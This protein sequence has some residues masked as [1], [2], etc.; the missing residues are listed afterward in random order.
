MVCPGWEIRFP[1]F[2]RLLFGRGTDTDIKYLGYFDEAYIGHVKNKELRLRGSSGGIITGLLIFLLEN[3]IIDGAIVTSMDRNNPWRPLP[4]LGKTK[5]QILEGAGSKYTVSPTNSVLK[6]LVNL[7][8]RFALV[9]LPCHVHGVRKIAK[10]YEQIRGKI[11]YVMGLFCSTTLEM[12]ATL[13]ILKLTGIPL[14]E[15]DELKYRFGQWPGAIVASKKDG[16]IKKLHYSNYKDGAY[17][18]LSEL[19]SPERC[20]YCID[21]C[22]EFAD[23]SVADAWTKDKNGNYLYQEGDS[24]ILVRT[25]AGKELVDF[26]IND[27]S[28]Y[29]ERVSAEMV[30]RTHL[31]ADEKKKKNAF[32][33]L[34]RLKRNK[35]HLP[36]YFLQ[37]PQISTKDRVREYFF[38]MIHVL[39]QFQKFRYIL[40]S[41]LLSRPGII[42]IKIRQNLKKER[43]SKKMFP[44]IVTS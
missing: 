10:I 34:Q 39:S 18:Y 4:I 42:F 12:Q 6:E 8:G 43:K 20:R 21:T 1:E 31:K 26:M 38:H 16:S 25:D 44:K 17:N 24:M 33:N 29:L 9:G 11:I 41:I 22:N 5:G 19:Y 30:Y 32:I 2:N 27:Q 13:D 14:N 23:I 37:A 35:R 40:L 3:N 28:F 36:L 15:L 7:Q